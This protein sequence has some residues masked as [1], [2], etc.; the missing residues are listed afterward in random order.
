MHTKSLFLLIMLMVLTS[1]CREIHVNT[2]V[3]NNGNILRSYKVITELHSA[4]KGSVETD[5]EL[6]QKMVRNIY[7]P[8]DSTWEIKAEKDT[9]NKK[10]ITKY[11]KLFDNIEGLQEYYET[12]DFLL[13]PISPE[14]SVKRSFKWFKTQNTF[15]ESF[16]PIFEGVD[17]KEF[18]TQQEI[19]TIRNDDILQ[20]SLLDL[21]FTKWVAFHIIHELAVMLENESDEA[22]NLSAWVKAMHEKIERQTLVSPATERNPFN[23]PELSN[24]Q[25][26]LD[27]SDSELLLESAIDYSGIELSETSKNKIDSLLN[28]KME[29][30]MSLYT[31]KMWFSVEMPG[32]ITNSNAD[33][34]NKNVAHWKM[35]PFIVGAPF[36]M[37]VVSEQSNA[38]III[39]IAAVLI[40]LLFLWLLKKRK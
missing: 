5:A 22:R 10:E 1:A 14:I 15:T 2:I 3:K 13:K 8:V 21:K 28:R 29:I 31:D 27:L 16:K 7:F 39:T 12:K 19:E 6:K 25:K 36:K 9:A 37:V 32:K 24:Q 11:T 20:D 4:Q 35:D 33:S 26:E 38:G 30:Y 17:Y 40:I 18:F 34:I 23:L